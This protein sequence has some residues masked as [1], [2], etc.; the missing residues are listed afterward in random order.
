MQSAG[1]IHKRKRKQQVENTLEKTVE[2]PKDIEAAECYRTGHY[3][4][5]ESRPLKVKFQSS[6]LLDEIT[7]FTSK[8]NDHKEYKQVKISWDLS[9]SKKK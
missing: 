5:G 1:Q 9:L 2:E 7:G 6:P 3:K 4:K 8:V